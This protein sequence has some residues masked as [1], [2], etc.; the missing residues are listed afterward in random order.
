VDVGKV[1]HE[2][3]GSYAV[4]EPGPR[5]VFSAIDVRKYRGEVDADLAGEKSSARQKSDSG[6]KDPFGLLRA[7]DAIVVMVDEPPFSFQQPAC[8]N[9]LSALPNCARIGCTPPAA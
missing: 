1:G 4:A 9:L 2:R 5:L 8:A 7:S 6:E 3:E